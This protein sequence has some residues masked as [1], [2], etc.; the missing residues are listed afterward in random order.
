MALCS[1]KTR[2]EHLET[3]V[4]A[5]AVKE[6]PEEDVTPRKYDR[7]RVSRVGGSYG[8]Y[9]F[10]NAVC[11]SEELSPPL[12]KICIKQYAGTSRS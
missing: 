10:R 3:W 2:R 1:C 9:V 6:T 7:L 5:R 8:N 12:R 4:R 11:L